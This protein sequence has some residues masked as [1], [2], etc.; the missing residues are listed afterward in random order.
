[1]G[2]VTRRSLCLLVA[3]AVLLAACGGGREALGP[4]V[5][6]VGPRSVYVAIGSDEELGEGSA[7]AL[8]SSWPQVFFRRTLPGN[9]VFVNAAAH[10][11]TVEAALDVQLPIARQ[12]RPTIVSVVLGAQE[13]LAGDPR[14]QFTDQL[15]KLLRSLRA[16][17]KTRVLVGS[18]VALPSLAPDVRTAR[19]AA[20]DAA[21]AKAAAATGAEV[22]P[23]GD[24][25]ATGDQQVGT[26]GR[27]DPAFP[28]DDHESEAVAAAFSK[29]FGKRSTPTS[30]R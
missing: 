13:E 1:M 23:L 11:A 20:Y 14:P 28:I 15:T 4:P 6:A 9:T 12:Q 16:I 2:P 5:A 17:D 25:T 29:A 10:D 3:G 19:K 26:N 8:Q 24:I 21:I 30:A 27:P 22:V 7:N 18:A